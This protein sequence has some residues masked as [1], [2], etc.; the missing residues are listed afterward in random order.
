MKFHSDMGV[1]NSNITANGS[2]SV[3]GDAMN[4]NMRGTINLV[5]ISMK[6]LILRLKI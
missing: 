1:P 4:P 3:I 6:D 2:V 5:D